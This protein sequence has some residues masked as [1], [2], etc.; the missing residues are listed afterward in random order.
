MANTNTP[1]GFRQYHGTGTTPSYEQVE[2][3]IVSTST[4]AI[5]SGD[6]VQQSA[7]TTGIGTG[8][9]Q[10]A[11]AP[12]AL[13][14]SGGVLTAG[15]MVITF[16]ATAQ[17]IPV[18]TWITLYGFTSTAATLNGSWQVTASSTT[19]ASFNFSGAF[20][21]GAGSGYAF[22]PVA[23]IFVGC[24]YLSSANK[25]TVWRNYW[26]GSDANGDVTA[27]IINDPNAQFVVQTAN[28]NTTATAVGLSSVGQNIGFAL[29]TGTTA[30]GQS[31]AYADQYTLP[32]NFPAGYA[33][34]NFLPF[35]VNALVNYVVG[36]SGVTPFQSINGNDSTTAFNYIVVG[37]NNSMPRG[38][39]GI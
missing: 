16:T 27:Y 32:A 33:C 1:F 19:T 4:T 24:K 35:R 26:P 34:N 18:G 7:S 8:Y 29:G 13:T 23:G 14:I 31:G 21:T 37:F 25:N 17:A 3:A 12:V 28:S 39:A 20:T 9:I 11:V 10:Q 22:P 36:T 30:N 5:Y 2:A 15:V 38:F 6:P